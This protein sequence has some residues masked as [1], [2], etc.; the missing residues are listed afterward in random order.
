MFQMTTSNFLSNFGYAYG[1]DS[2]ITPIP[3]QSY[4]CECNRGQW[5]HNIVAAEGNVL[6]NYVTINY[7]ISQYLSFNI[8]TLSGFYIELFEN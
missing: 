7:V 2:V 3:Q 4:S 5:C 1:G 6:E 8:T